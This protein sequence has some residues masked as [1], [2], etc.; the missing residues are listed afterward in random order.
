MSVVTQEDSPHLRAIGVEWGCR[1]WRRTGTSKAGPREGGPIPRLMGKVGK[2]RGNPG[3][4]TGN[5]AW[6]RHGTGRGAALP[7]C[8]THGQSM[9]PWFDVP[10]NASL[11]RAWSKAMARSSITNLLPISP[12]TGSGSVHGKESSLNC[13]N[14]SRMSMT[15]APWPATFALRA[16]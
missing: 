7:A 9:V 3:P 15:G 12:Q 11:V 10:G 4:N 1:N 2:V 14:T 6:C 8:V 16:W 5:E 13:E